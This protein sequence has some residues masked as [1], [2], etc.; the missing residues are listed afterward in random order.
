MSSSSGKSAAVDIGRGRLE[1]LSDAVPRTQGPQHGQ[2]WQEAYGGGIRTD[3]RRLGTEAA[4][5]P[6]LGVRQRRR[7]AGAG[8][9]SRRMGHRAAGEIKKRTPGE[10]RRKNQ[11]A[12][13]S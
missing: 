3:P 9:G 12:K 13:P 5:A 8:A 11:L 6:A 10:A 2:A 7:T 4:R 1:A